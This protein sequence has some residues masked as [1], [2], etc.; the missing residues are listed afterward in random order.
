MPRQIVEASESWSE[1]IDIRVHRWARRL[2]CVTRNPRS[3]Q[4]PPPL[5]AAI[6]EC[7][8]RTVTVTVT[9]STELRPRDC[10][11]LCCQPA[12]GPQ[13]RTPRAG[14]GLLPACASRP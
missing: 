10:P 12:G 3:L 13:A 11:G 1:S 2:S 7:S 4:S 14:G 8:D 6:R 9:N 5:W